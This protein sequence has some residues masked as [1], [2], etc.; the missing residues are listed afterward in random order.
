MPNDYEVPEVVALGRP[1][2]VIFGSTR[3]TI[4]DDSPL[5]GLRETVIENDE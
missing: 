1:Q 2:D 3:F 5:E 4:F